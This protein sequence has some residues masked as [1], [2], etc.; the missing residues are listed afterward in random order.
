MHCSVYPY[1]SWCSVS[2]GNPTMIKPWAQKAG[3]KFNEIHE[4]L[5]FVSW[6]E[7]GICVGLSLLW[8]ICLGN[9]CLYTHGQYCWL[10]I[11]VD[12]K[13][14]HPRPP[15]LPPPFP[16]TCWLSRLI[17]PNHSTRN[18]SWR[19]WRL[20]GFLSDVHGGYYLSGFHHHVLL[21]SVFFALLIFWCSIICQH[22][23]KL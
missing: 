19:S 23:S 21:Y 15:P 5:L 2:K 18:Y 6:C 1:V 12:G 14:V 9:S 22:L 20:N 4:L 16:C 7:C 8:S 11:K 10:L 3:L 13:K 17:C